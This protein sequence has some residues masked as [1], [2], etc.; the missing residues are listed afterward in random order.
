MQVFSLSR[1]RNPPI[2]QKYGGC[3]GVYSDQL[4]LGYIFTH[5][6]NKFNNVE[7]YIEKRARSE[8]ETVT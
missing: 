8:H 1:S 3:D 6:L 5:F 7:V 4:S 2:S